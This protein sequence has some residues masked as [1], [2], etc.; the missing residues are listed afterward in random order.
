MTPPNAKSYKRRVV[1]TNLYIVYVNMALNTKK[2][3]L[4]DMP[5]VNVVILE[6]SSIP[7]LS[8]LYFNANLRSKF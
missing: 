1:K 7:P 6:M 8:P 3:E 2:M 5:H 4:N